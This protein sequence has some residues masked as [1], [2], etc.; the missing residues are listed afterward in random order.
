MELIVQKRA[1]NFILAFI[2]LLVSFSAFGQDTSVEEKL[3]KLGTEYEQATE[4]NDLPKQLDILLEM[5]LLITDTYGEDN[6][7]LGFIYNAIGFAYFQ[8][9]DYSQA[10]ENL[11]KA[12][13]VLSGKSELDVA[14]SYSVMSA[15]YVSLGDFSLALES[16]EKTLAIELEVLGENHPDVAESYEGIGLA[17]SM[18]AKYPLALENYENALD[19]QLENLGENHPDVAESYNNI[20]DVYDS[21]GDYS[22]ALEYKQKSLA[23][24]VE[25]LGENHPDVANSYSSVGRHFISIGNYTLAVEY[26]E[27]A[28]DI[29]L[30]VLG[31]K[32]ETTLVSYG[33]IGIAYTLLGDSSS[34]IEY[35]NK[36]LNVQ[37]E[38]LG[39]KHPVVAASYNRIGLAYN[40]V[41]DYPLALENFK[42]AL[43]IQLDALG[44]NHPEVATSYNNIGSVY[45]SLRNFPLALDNF[46]KALNIMLDVLGENSI[47]VANGYSNIGGVYSSLG[48]YS[49]ALENQEKGVALYL[50]IFGEQ[51]PNLAMSYRNLSRTYY[52][53]GNFAESLS[54]SRKAM[55]LSLYFQNQSFSLLDSKSKLTYNRNLQPSFFF[56]FQALSST[57]DV[58]SYSPVYTDWLS[59]K[60][61]GV[62]LTNG[63]SEVL[64]QAQQ[65]G[66]EALQSQLEEYN[67]ARI[68][69]GSLYLKT[70]TAELDVEQQKQVIETLSK[71]VKDLEV[72]LANKNDT[73]KVLLDLNTLI[74]DDLAGVLQVNERFIDFAVFPDRL[75]AF[76]IDSNK[77]VRFY[78]LGET[79]VVLSQLDELRS[80]LTQQGEL[81]LDTTTDTYKT[82][83]ESLYKTLLAPVIA[84]LPTSTTKLIVSPDGQLSFLPFELLMDSVTQQYLVGR[85]SISYT[86]TARD[87]V[88][89]R[90]SGAVA[91]QGEVVLVGAPSYDSE[92][93]VENALTL[94]NPLVQDETLASQ[95]ERSV[96]LVNLDTEAK[97]TF[98]SNLGKV[99]ALPDTASEVSA[100]AEVLEQQG[101]GA[102]V[103]LGDDATQEN[104]L[105][106]KSPRI[107]H[108]ATHGFFFGEELA[109][110]LPNPWLRSGLL[111]AG[112]EVSRTASL[113]YG[114]VNAF[115]LSGLDL[116]GTELVV[117]SACETGLGD[118]LAGEGVSGLQQ[119]FLSAGARQIV[120]S[121]WKVPSAETS[122][123]MQT[124]YRNYFV[125]NDSTKALQITKQEF[126]KQGYSPWVWAAFIVSGA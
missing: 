42:K 87:L 19:I 111:L 24:R 117:L 44:E 57:G 72:E 102:S 49:L 35:F 119:A 21:L 41:G 88:R 95:V 27:K 69:L 13:S 55:N 64:L 37:L 109:E 66:D 65:S 23:I 20:G 39:N 118:A 26:F 51:H 97:T 34:A 101:I 83:T 59:F 93:L 11:K 67:Q 113:D 28:L 82:V 70:E 116:R 45:N 43:A 71:R 80:S 78:D 32:H 107:L 29:Q 16:L 99:A 2:V 48:N 56:Y 9:N 58:S 110:A 85:F 60:G 105:A 6:E 46:E 84:D 73:F 12:V 104:L 50:D 81:R 33:G 31:N 7:M 125:L 47:D 112:A 114:I 94:Q 77:T 86:P 103:L 92:T 91:T 98:F 36:A 90:R 1:T 10:L 126:I 18:L 68:A 4:T 106:V 79:P 5:K 25:T 100:I 3:N 63:L 74:I 122:L 30:E 115:K 75:Y 17:Y 121:L 124:F 123:F 89:L 8:Y 76:D 96:S 120:M 62:S 38:V 40:S 61:S 15:V 22:L 14:T 108:L 54:L 52:S 53:L